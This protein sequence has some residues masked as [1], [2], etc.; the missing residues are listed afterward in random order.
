MKFQRQTY[1][2]EQR[3]ALRKLLFIGV[4]KMENFDNRF[5]SQIVALDGDFQPTTNINDARWLYSSNYYD[6][7]IVRINADG[8]MTHINLED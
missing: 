3:D 8:S 6:D 1:S 5:G 2:Y 7:A 4:D